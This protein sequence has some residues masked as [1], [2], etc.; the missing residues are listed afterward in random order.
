MKYKCSQ[1]DYVSDK[2]SRVNS[3]INKIKKCTEEVKEIIEIPYIIKCEFC[4]RDFS[5]SRSLNYHITHHCTKKDLIKDAKIKNLEKQINDTKKENFALL[6]STSIKGGFIYLIRDR[7]SFR[8]NEDVYKF[9]YTERP[10]IQRF[11]DYPPGS[12][13]ITFIKI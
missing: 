2:K 4:K 12:E 3:H 5:C 1:C 13:I 6:S 11:K 7:E 10:L 9:G 8:L